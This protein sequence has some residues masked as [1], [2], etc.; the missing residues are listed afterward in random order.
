MIWKL[1]SSA[2]GCDSR[3]SNT[4]FIRHRTE[5]I[6][7]MNDVFSNRLRHGFRSCR[8]GGHV[9][10]LI[11]LAPKQHIE[12]FAVLKNVVRMWVKLL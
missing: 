7:I 8:Q 12:W 2:Q 10:L 11:I 4:L 3:L 9:P 6:Y 1:F 5:D